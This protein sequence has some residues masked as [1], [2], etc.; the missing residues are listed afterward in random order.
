M[1]GW[2]RECKDHRRTLICNAAAHSE[3]W[4]GFCVTNFGPAKLPV[5]RANSTLVDYTS[6]MI[7]IR[8]RLVPAK[9]AIRAFASSITL[10]MGP[11]GEG[12]WAAAEPFGLLCVAASAELSS[13]GDA[14]CSV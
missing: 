12:A 14:S 5:G 2:R 10:P 3:E 4:Q 13:A 1:R 11:T 6:I 7:L 9:A 8:S